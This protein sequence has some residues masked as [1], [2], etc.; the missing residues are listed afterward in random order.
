MTSNDIKDSSFSFKYCRGKNYNKDLVLLGN[1]Y[2]VDQ[3]SANSFVELGTKD[4]PFKALDDAFRELFSY[5]IN[6][7]SHSINGTYKIL[8]KYGS[9]LTIHSVDM[10]L[11]ALNSKI[12]IE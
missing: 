12:V 2:Y 6:S 10:P 9:N 7:A 3:S 1:N 5:A 4:Y 8:I 11:I